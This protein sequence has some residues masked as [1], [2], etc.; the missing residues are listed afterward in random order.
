MPVVLGAALPH[1]CVYLGEDRPPLTE[2]EEGGVGEAS[3]AAGDVDGGVDESTLEPEGAASSESPGE[4]LGAALSPPT[5]LPGQLAALCTQTR[6]G[7]QAAVGRGCTC[8]KPEDPPPP[9]LSRSCQAFRDKG[10]PFLVNSSPAGD[11][12]W[13]CHPRHPYP[14]L[15]PSPGLGECSHLTWPKMAP[16]SPPSPPRRQQDAAKGGLQTQVGTCSLQLPTHHVLPGTPGAESGPSSSV[17]GA[18][19]GSGEPLSAWSAVPQALV[20]DSPSSGGVFGRCPQDAAS[21]GHLAFPG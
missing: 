5:A 16:L 3:L 18:E 15:P 10:G 13:G 9:K 21:S 12:R 8:G 7:G 1:G 4:E 14:P 17:R 2:G 11:E 20:K 6:Q 19:L